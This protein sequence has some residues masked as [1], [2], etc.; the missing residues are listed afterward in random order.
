MESS[1]DLSHVKQWKETNISDTIAF[2]VTR[3]LI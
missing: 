3:H 1:W 2:P